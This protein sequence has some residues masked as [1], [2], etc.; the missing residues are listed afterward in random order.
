MGQRFLLYSPEERYSLRRCW[1]PTWD[2]VREL[3]LK[4][5]SEGEKKGVLLI[6]LAPLLP[7]L[8]LPFSQHSQHKFPFCLLQFGLVSCQ[9]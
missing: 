8:L 5:L 1:Q 6:S 2:Q 9:L 7:F 4:K 3:T